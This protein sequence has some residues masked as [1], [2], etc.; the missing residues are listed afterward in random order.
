MQI[1]DPQM[2]RVYEEAIEPAI[3]DAG[4]APLRVDRH[5]QGDL[6]KSE[7]V[8]FLETSEVIVADITNERPN[9]YL[10]IGYAMGLGKKRNLILTAREDHHHQSSNFRQGGP[11]VH[12]DLEGY[13]IIFWDPE[14]LDGFRKELGRAISRRRATVRPTSPTSIA[15]PGPW[16]EELRAIAE[17]GISGVGRSAYMEVAAEVESPQSF[18]QQELLQALR[19]SSIHTFGWPIGVILDTDADAR[20]HPTTDGVQAEVAFASEAEAAQNPFGQD[21][22]SY[23][24]WKLFRDGRFYTLLSLF[25]DERAENA[26]FFDV[27]IS[28]VT[29]ALLLLARLY[30]RLGLAETDRIAVSIRHQGLAGRTI[31]AAAPGRHLRQQSTRED[32][33]E[34][35]ITATLAELERDLT[36]YVRQV[37]DPLFVVFDFLQIGEEIVSELVEDFVGGQIR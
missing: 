19:D 28:R 10:E 21:R 34:S 13:A 26:I 25:E 3:R 4:M 33:V 23:D 7:I 30:R 29:E 14:D 35:T 22:A 8:R 5:N 12:F 11:R 16:Q 37:I 9:C 1:G 32:C 31:R 18:D 20:P 36:A 17:T 27:R 15:A 6:L 2:D 24:F